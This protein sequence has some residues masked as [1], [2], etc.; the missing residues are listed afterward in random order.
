MWVDGWISSFWSSNRKL[1]T[2]TWTCVNMCD[3]EYNPNAYTQTEYHL[4][5]RSY[6]SFQCCC[7]LRFTCEHTPKDQ[8]LISF[9]FLVNFIQVCDSCVYISFLVD[10]NLVSFFLHQYIATIYFSCS[11]QFI[12]IFLLG[13]KYQHKSIQ[14]NL[15]LAH[16]CT[17]VLVFIVHGAIFHFG[18]HMIR[19]ATNLPIWVYFNFKSLTHWSGRWSR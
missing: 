16:I 3:T 2:N 11:F 17:M 18:T 13:I 12:H 4:L 6:G 14:T 9:W 7:T 15:Y 8:T 19:Q 5:F 10:H 1:T